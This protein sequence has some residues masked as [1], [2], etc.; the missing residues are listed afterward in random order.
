M[1][2]EARP[3]NGKIR[4]GS[5]ML[6]FGA[7]KPGVKGGPGSPPPRIRACG[8]IEVGKRTKVFVYFVSTSY[9][10]RIHVFCVY[11]R[12]EPISKFNT[13]QWRIQDF[14]EEGA[15][16]PQVG[17][18]HMILPYF[19]KNC[20]KLEEFGPHGGARPSHPPLRSATA[21]NTLASWCSWF[22][23]VRNEFAKVMFLQACVCP[24]W[25]ST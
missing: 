16:T 8:S 20:M 1:P 4:Q 12:I 18:Q 2:S 19:P 11:F 23:T 21:I 5:K 6:N 17:C 9:K 3:K 25:G 24:Q 22:V 7:S 14:P 15:P 13:I 10:T